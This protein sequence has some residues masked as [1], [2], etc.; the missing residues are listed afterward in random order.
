MQHRHYAAPNPD[1]TGWKLYL[2]LD[3]L[4]LEL[5]GALRQVAARGL[6][7][8]LPAQTAASLTALLL[9]AGADSEFPLRLP[10]GGPR[11]RWLDPLHRSKRAVAAGLGLEPLAE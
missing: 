5:N 10:L 8:T 11:E 2:P 6:R 1:G 9:G 4:L 7:P 3:K